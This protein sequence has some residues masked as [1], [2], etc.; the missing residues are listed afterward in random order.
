MREKEFERIELGGAGGWG[1]KGNGGYGERSLGVL[2][3]EG[4]VVC[5]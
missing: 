1:E 5:W 4:V 3:G 2:W